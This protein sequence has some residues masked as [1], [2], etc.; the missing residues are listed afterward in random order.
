MTLKLTGDFGALN[1]LIGTLAQ[2]G[3]VLEVSS[4]AMA[5]EAIDLTKDT[6]RSETDPYGRPWTP[7][8]ANDGRKT[9][10]G[11]TSRLKGGWK[12]T[13]TDQEGFEIEAS[14][15][16]AV[17]HQRPKKRKFR[18]DGKSLTRRQVPEQSLGLPPEWEDRLQGAAAEV[19]EAVYGRG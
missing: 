10:S 4:K 11:E 16:Y 6:Y 14:V 17:Y 5:E 7:K 18:K 12:R 13:R 3:R 2:P 9:L 1:D 19:M 8:L 15:E